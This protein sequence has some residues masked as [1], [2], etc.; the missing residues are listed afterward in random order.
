MVTEARGRGDSLA[1]LLAEFDATFGFFASDQVSVRVDD[2]SSIARIMTTLREQHPATIGALAVERVEDLLEGVD[3]LPVGDILRL[4]MTDGSRVIIRPSGTEPKLKLYLDV[5][6]DSAA[7]AKARIAA[8][9]AG[10]RALL[11]EVG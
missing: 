9:S 2:V 3:D 6:G 4:W 1:R 10:A 7:D 8:L 11:D 5:R